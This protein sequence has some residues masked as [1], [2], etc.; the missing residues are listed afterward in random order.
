MRPASLSGQAMAG[1]GGSPGLVSGPVGSFTQK[2]SD[3]GEDG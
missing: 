3:N 2:E 1:A